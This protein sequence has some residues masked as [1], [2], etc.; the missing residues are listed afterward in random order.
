MVLSVFMQSNSYSSTNRVSMVFLITFSHII[1]LVDVKQTLMKK[2]QGIIEVTLSNRLDIYPYGLTNSN[3]T[4]F[5]LYSSLL[6]LSVRNLILN[7][8]N[9]CVWDGVRIFFSSL[10]MK[11]RKSKYDINSWAAYLNS[12]FVFASKQ[13][14]SE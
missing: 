2:F 6:V 4:C 9:F 5:V 7:P 13:V 8:K 14:S 3:D 12:V 1:I 10:I 11:L